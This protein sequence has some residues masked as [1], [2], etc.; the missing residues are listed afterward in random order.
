MDNDLRQRAALRAALG[1]LQ[2]IALYLLHHSIGA[3]IWPATEPLVFAPMLLVAAIVPLIALFGLG[4]LR[5]RTLFIWMGGA[6]LILTL[7]ALHDKT[8]QVLVADA[9]SSTIAITSPS[10]TL[11]GFALLGVFIAHSLITAGDSD[12]RFVASYP[13][14]FETAWKLELQILLTVMFVGLFWLLLWLGAEL[15]ELIKIGFLRR[16]I[17]HDWFAFPATALA[18]STAIHL[19]DVRSNIISGMRS[20]IHIVLSW[21]L[22]MIAVITGIF[23]FSLPVT[24]L[25]PLWQ[26]SHAASL[27][28]TVAAVTIILINAVYRD[29]TS[30]HAPSRVLR[31]SASIAVVELVPIVGIAALAIALRIDQHGWS[32]SRVFATAATVVAAC[33]AV[34]YFLAIVRRSPWLRGLERCNVVASFVILATLLTLLT[35]LGDPAR[36]AVASQVA[37]LKSGRVAPDRFD[38][39][40]LRWHGERYGRDALEG[41]K[42]DAGGNVAI[43]DGADRALN[44]SGPWSD[45]VNVPTDAELAAAITVYPAGRSLPDGFLQ[46][47]R[48][49][50]YLPLPLCLSNKAF[51]CDAFFIDLDGDGV[52]EIILITTPR[53]YNGTVFKVDKDG[54]WQVVGSLSNDLGC[55]GALDALRA[56]QYSL[57]ASPWKDMVVAGQTVRMGGLPGAAHCH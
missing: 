11:V 27:L 47:R 16:L 9:V 51:R 34:G 37:L 55:D 28:L 5:V 45:K 29:G 3:K 43:R 26:T 31:I 42:A 14:Y 20:L 41:M 40:Y 6:G 52:D 4:N 49:G 25:G 8:R 13:Q 21:L 2:G 22:P 10:W 12:R 30:D 46:H 32:V 35:P 48:E 38:Y 56:G 18:L 24:G 1:F 19:T 44:G 54:N 23:L 17:G 36:V 53:G 7:L 57:A 15:L 39:A 50:T 33:Y